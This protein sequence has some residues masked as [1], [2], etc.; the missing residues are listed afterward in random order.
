MSGAC[1]GLIRKVQKL[2]SFHRELAEGPLLLH[3]PFVGS[4]AKTAASPPARRCLRRTPSSGVGRGSKESP[5]GETIATGLPS[6][7]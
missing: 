5:A 2:Q 6:P 4:T 3:Q 7:G 1:A